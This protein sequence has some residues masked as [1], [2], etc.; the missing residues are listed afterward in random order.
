MDKDF[1]NKKS[2]ADRSSQMIQRKGGDFGETNVLS[3]CYTKKEH[4]SLQKGKKNE[5][6]VGLINAQFMSTDKLA[7]HEEKALQRDA[8]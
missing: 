1:E 2:F 8:D 6:I 7:S 4:P 5:Y 3:Y